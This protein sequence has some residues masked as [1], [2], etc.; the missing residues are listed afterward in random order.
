MRCHSHFAD[1][2]TKALINLEK[3]I[4]LLNDRIEIHKNE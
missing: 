4:Q 3:I 2:K 1:K